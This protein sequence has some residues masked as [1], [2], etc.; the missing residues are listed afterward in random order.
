MGKTKNG[1]RSIPDGKVQVNFNISSALLEQVK[2]LAFWENVTCSDIYNKSVLKFIE[3]Y[4]KKNGKIKRRLRGRG[5][6]NL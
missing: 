3:L 5:L 1:N 2:D 4:E 6:D